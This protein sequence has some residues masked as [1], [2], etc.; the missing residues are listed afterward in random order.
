MAIRAWCNKRGYNS[1]S[2][3]KFKKGNVPW[4]TGLS[5]EE[6]KSHY[7]EES[8]QRLLYGMQ[9]ANKTKKIGDEVIKNGVPAVVV[10]LNYGDPQYKRIEFK[11]R[12]V[13]ERLHGEIPKDHRIIHLDG[14]QMNCDPSN[15]YCVPAKFVPILSHNHWWSENPE[16]TRTAIKWCELFYAI[17]EG[18]KQ[19]SE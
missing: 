15:L 13:W 6:L 9:Q 3:G 7:T 16:L 1:P 8:F 10:N 4:I 14:N 18:V 17:K 19:S 11:R 12:V 5:G 2:D